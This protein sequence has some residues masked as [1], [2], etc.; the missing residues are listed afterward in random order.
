MN[1]KEIEAVG[2]LV[3]EFIDRWSGDGV[4]LEIRNGYAE[5]IIKALD[6]A[7]GVPVNTQL[8]E[9]LK[10][11]AQIAA[12]A[13]PNCGDKLR[14]LIQKAQEKHTALM[15]FKVSESQPTSKVNAALIE[16]NERLKG[17][18]AQV[19]ERLEF[20]SGYLIKEHLAKNDDNW[21]NIT[22][23]K[24]SPFSSCNLL[25]SLLSDNLKIINLAKQALNGKEG[26]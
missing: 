7:R 26:V 9:A 14:G 6:E 5:E 3:N 15:T 8:L 12:I 11:F 13:K 22:A 4:T 1:D 2:Y 23:E 21:I 20:M 18:L 24:G 25:N 17:V 10:D 19:Y 16:E